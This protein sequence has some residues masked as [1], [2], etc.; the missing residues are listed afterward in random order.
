M[1][2]LQDL[3]NRFVVGPVLLLLLLAEVSDHLAA[4]AH[5]QVADLVRHRADPEPVSVVSLLH[6]K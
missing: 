2:R 4:A 1:H 3:A 6:R 5:L